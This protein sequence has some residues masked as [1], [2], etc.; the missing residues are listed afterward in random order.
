MIPFSFTGNA[1]T[2]LSAGL[3]DIVVKRASE[4]V[5]S[6]VLDLEDAGGW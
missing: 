6:M 3:A 4:G 5:S 2:T 1:G